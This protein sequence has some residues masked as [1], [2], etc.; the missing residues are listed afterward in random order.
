[1][2]ERINPLANL[3]DFTIKAP[4]KKPKP[5]PEAIEKLSQETGFLSRQPRQISAEPAKRTQR[6]YTTGRNVQIPIKGTAETRA[7]L[8]ALADELQEPFGEVL[9]RALAALRRELA[10]R[11]GT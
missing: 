10:V 5:Q 4:E 11:N 3:D 6:R 9:A 8:E 7:Q 1:M 2:S